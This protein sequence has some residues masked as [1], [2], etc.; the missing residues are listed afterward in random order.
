MSK[1]DVKVVI[2]GRSAVGKSCLIERFIY[3]TF[4]SNSPATVGSAYFS[5]REVVEDRP[6]QLGIWDTAGAERFESMTKIYY[7]GSAAALVCFDL[8]DAD[9]FGR[10]NFW[11][12]ELKQNVSTCQIYLVGCKVDLIQSGEKK[13][14]ITPE[15]VARFAD[16]V[17][18]RAVFETSARNGT[19]VEELFHRL[20]ADWVKD[21]PNFMDGSAGTASNGRVLPPPSSQATQESSNCCFSS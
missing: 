4:Q 13:R 19:G 3:G 5:K 21:N 15:D 18:V 8:T 16:A 2:L 12:N 11:M 14:A 7:R 9:S 17:G 6:V 20:A 1:I 10:A